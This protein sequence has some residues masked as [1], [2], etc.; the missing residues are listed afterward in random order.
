MDFFMLR[1]WISQDKSLFKL[2]NQEWTNSFLDSVM[3]FMTEFHNTWIL[4]LVGLAIWIAIQKMHAVKIIL[5]CVVAVAI[6]DSVSYRIVKN[7]V[8]RPRPQFAETNVRLLVPSRTGP[9]FPSNHAANS[10]A[11]AAY[12]GLHAPLVAAIAYPIAWLIS[13]SRVYVGVHYPGDVFIGALIGFICAHI[14]NYLIFN[15]F[16]FVGLQTRD[17]LPEARKERAWRKRVQKR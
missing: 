1:A 9:S 10:F 15:L 3:P 14:A 13:Y 11:A 8:D 17:P 5:G 6:S 16:S 12:I 4:L 7:I 2:I